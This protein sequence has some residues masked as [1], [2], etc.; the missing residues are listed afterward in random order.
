MY[1][2]ITMIVVLLL[3]VWPSAWAEPFKVGISVPLTGAASTYGEDVKNILIADEKSNK[4]LNAI[5]KVVEFLQ[6]D[7]DS[8]YLTVMSNNISNLSAEI[9]LKLD[10]FME[11]M[12]IPFRSE[13]FLLI[14]FQEL[15]EQFVSMTD[16]KK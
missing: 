15:Y 5:R 3:T 10:S 14:L 4:F 12:K 16:N 9:S 7:D 6:V 1:K 2:L 11:E 13:E 8:P